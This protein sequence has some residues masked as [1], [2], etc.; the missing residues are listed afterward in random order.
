[1]AL[2]L[3]A[4]QQRPKPVRWPD[5]IKLQ[6]EETLWRELDDDRSQWTIRAWLVLNGNSIPLNRS[7]HRHDR[8]SEPVRPKRKNAELGL[9]WPSC[10]TAVETQFDSPPI[11]VKQ[12]PQYA[13]G[14]H[15]GPPNRHKQGRGRADRQRH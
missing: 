6:S 11:V 2:V 5:T 14:G 4:R 15:R 13:A 9:F 7:S 12:Q 1:M 8:Q 3:E 10:Q